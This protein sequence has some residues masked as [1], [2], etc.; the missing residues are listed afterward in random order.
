M[1]VVSGSQGVERRLLAE[2]LFQAHVLH[3]LVHRD[4]PGS[5]DH[6]LHAMGF[7]HLGE[8]AQGFQ[9][10]ELGGVVGVGDG[11][12]PQPVTEGEGDVV[13]GQDLAQLVE[14]G[15]QEGFPVVG[16]HPGGHDG[17]TAADDPGHPLVG[18]PD[19]AGQHP[20]VPV[21]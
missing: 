5:L 13:A 17:A 6:H 7:R 2:V 3:D 1:S 18:Q 4:V 8:L 20:G 14:V 11:A 10:G 16:Q 9:L 19:V 21:M 12:G 15:V